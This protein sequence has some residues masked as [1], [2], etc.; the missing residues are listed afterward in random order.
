MCLHLLFDVGNLGHQVSGQ[1]LH[2]VVHRI[3]PVVERRMFLQVGVY[4]PVGNRCGEFVQ[5]R[6]VLCDVAVLFPFLHG[7]CPDHDVG[8]ACHVDVHVAEPYG[9][10]CGVFEGEGL[11]D[12]GLDNISL[13]VKGGDDRVL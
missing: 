2:C 9:Q 3:E 5:F 8:Q 7:L 11:L 12:V 10:R 6:F 1:V 4:F 13:P